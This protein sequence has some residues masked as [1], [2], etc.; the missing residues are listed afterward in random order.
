MSNK[1]KNALWERQ[2]GESAKAYEAF[3]SYRDF[4]AE[5]SIQKV[6]Q[7]LSKSL[8]LIKRWSSEWNW[9]ERSR[10]WDNE[11][12]Q[13][14]KAAA[15]KRVRDMT[16]RHINIAMQLQKKALEALAALD[17]EEMSPKDIKEFI[18]AA[19]ELERANRLAEA[20]LDRDGHSTGDGGGPRS[21]AD[22]IMEAYARR[23][24]EDGQC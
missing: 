9:V 17:L 15:V 21:L 19:T 18:K 7:A 6:S 3:A 8:T 13:Q 24:E 10:A 4:G 23:K 22:A 16:G 2:P 20:E 12:A 11:L 1:D 5:R 14:A